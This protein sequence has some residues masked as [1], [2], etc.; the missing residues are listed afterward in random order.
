MK[1]GIYRFSKLFAVLAVFALVAC[2]HG[3]KHGELSVS[4][5]VLVSAP[6]SEVW[7]TVG[8]Y[9]A[10]HNW[11]P[12]VTSTQ[13]SGQKDV[14]ILILG[15]GSRVYEKLTNYKDGKSF[16]Y[17]MTDV[18]PL[19][20]KNYASTITV[21]KEGNGSRVIWSANFDAADG[22]ESEKAIETMTSVFRGGLDNLAT[23]YR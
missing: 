5:E 12:A 15:D 13:Q 10:L 22:V 3:H 2:K 1:I 4:E 23:M 7:G 6:Q 14:R 9:Y 18:G 17:D 21:E 20:V 16:S 19:P 8:D 11:H